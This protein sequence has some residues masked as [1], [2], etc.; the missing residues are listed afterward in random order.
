VWGCFV[1]LVAWRLEDGSLLLVATTDHPEQALEDYAHRWEI[2]CLFAAL[3]RRGFR[4]E[5]TH[6]TDPERLSRLIAT[7]AIAFAWAYRGGE[8][9]SQQQ[10]IPFKKP[11]DGLSRPSSVTGST[12]CATSC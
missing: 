7:L 11:S 3:K 12:S 9:L 10:P 1:F 5:D 2:E 6:L 8:V 4:F